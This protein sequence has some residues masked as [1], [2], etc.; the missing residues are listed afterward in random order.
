MRRHLIRMICLL[1][2]SDLLNGATAVQET[3]SPTLRSSL[4]SSSMYNEV[5]DLYIRAAQ[6]SPHSNIDAEVQVTTV[7]PF[8]QSRRSILTN[9]NWYSWLWW[10]S[11]TFDSEDDHHWGHQN[12]SHYDDSFKIWSGNAPKVFVLSFCSP[13]CNFVHGARSLNTL[14]FSIMKELSKSMSTV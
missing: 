2:Y 4:M 11:N 5:R 7:L 13:L 12:V 9:N 6:L 10:P 8:F 3:G 1:R 14:Y